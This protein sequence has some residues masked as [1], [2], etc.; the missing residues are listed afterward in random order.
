M[1]AFC[2][3]CT[4]QV[5]LS[6]NLRK[7][8]SMM[9]F[10]LIWQKIWHDSSHCFYFS[11]SM[12]A[13]MSSSACFSLL[14]QVDMF[15]LVL[16]VRHLSSSQCLLSFLFGLLLGASGEHILFW[17]NS[18]IS[19]SSAWHKLFC[20]C[21]SGQLCVQ[22]CGTKLQAQCFCKV[23][24]NVRGQH[25]MSSLK[26]SFTAS[27]L[28][29]KLLLANVESSW[30]RVVSILQAISSTLLMKFWQFEGFVAPCQILLK[31]C[32]SLCRLA[33]AGLCAAHVIW[34]HGH[35]L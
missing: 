9:L 11:G 32:C 6:Q 23:E 29:G 14:L 26:H 21:L 25:S 10:L 22:W 19:L 8:P 34:P 12:H 30:Q 31:P 7:L 2:H 35:S 27:T 15:S 1:C 20:H 5:S 4:A 16:S 24:S 33:A 18:E 13:L 3:F 17:I 28:H